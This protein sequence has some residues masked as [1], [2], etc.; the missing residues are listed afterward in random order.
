MAA[1]LNVMSHTMKQFQTERC[2]A[3]GVTDSEREKC[4]A[5]VLLCTFRSPGT[6]QWFGAQTSVHGAT[7][8]MSIASLLE[9]VHRVYVKPY[10]SKHKA[11][12]PV[13][14][15][16]AALKG[17][18]ASMQIPLAESYRTTLAE[19]KEAVGSYEFD[20]PK[21]RSMARFFDGYD[22]PCLFGDESSPCRDS[23]TE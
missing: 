14:S 5:S 9:T 8:H 21:R 4:D 17:V 10:A 16:C 7:L 20:A 19:R 23:R 3:N 12:S 2:A 13:P 6:E 1:M 15:L 11:C 22:I 18:V